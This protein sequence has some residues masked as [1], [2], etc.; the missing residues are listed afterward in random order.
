MTAD[1]PTTAQS[2]RDII[3]GRVRKALAQA[4]PAEISIPRDYEPPSDDT[5]SADVLD[6][7][8]Q[9]LGGYDAVVRR[10]SGDGV[11]EAVAA[12]LRERGARR[13]VVPPGFP[14]DHLPA[15]GA[16]W[17]RDEPPLTVGELDAVD[18]VVTTAAVAVADS[19]TL[20]LDGSSG[21]GRRALSLVPD[22]MVVVVTADQV[23]RNLPA[24]IARLDGRRPMTFVSG[25]SATVDIEL[26]RVAGVHG[27][28]NL[29]VVLVS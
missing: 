24:G 16:E 1:Q 17:V 10:V 21:Q 19:G 12:A 25:P 7:F 11:R 3:L 26:V 23:V 14:D 22:S 5:G 29:D 8:A 2:G 13:V 28:R 9:R 6:L 4:D 27:P 18:G 15:E 20:V